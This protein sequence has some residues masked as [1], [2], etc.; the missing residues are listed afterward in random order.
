MTANDNSSC[1]SQYVTLIGQS[2][3]LSR[4]V[5]TENEQQAIKDPN[6]AIV[7]TIQT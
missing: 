6:K 4:V 3:R 7:K 1:K 2:T 5:F